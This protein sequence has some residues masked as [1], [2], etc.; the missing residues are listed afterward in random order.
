MV[1]TSDFGLISG[2][3]SSPSLKN[4]TCFLICPWKKYLDLLGS[5]I[6]F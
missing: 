3:E 6:Q 1:S 2:V 5:V 4:L